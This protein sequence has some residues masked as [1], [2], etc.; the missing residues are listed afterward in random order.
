MTEPAPLEARVIG[1][2]SAA[3][4]VPVDRLTP[5]ASPQDLGIDSLGLVES[6][7][8]LEEEFGIRLPFDAHQTGGPPGLDVATLGGLVA[9][10]AALVRAQA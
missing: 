6:I 2:I 4:L 1:V 5:D 3:T 10:V 7:F 8:A 9:G